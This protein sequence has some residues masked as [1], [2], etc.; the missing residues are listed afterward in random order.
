MNRLCGLVFH[1]PAPSSLRASVEGLWNLCNLG[2][3]SPAPDWYST[4]SANIQDG[5]VQQQLWGETALLAVARKFS[6]FQSH[7]LLL[8]VLLVFI[9][10]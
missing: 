3:N 1:F 5:Y 4:E 9:L 6:T 2:R 10:I 7:L 8:L